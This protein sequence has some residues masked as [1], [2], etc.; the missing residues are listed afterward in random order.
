MTL[1]LHASGEYEYLK[2]LK[3]F[4][5]NLISQLESNKSLPPSQKKAEIDRL[6]VEYD[7]KRKLARFG[8]F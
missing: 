5:R 6:K 7:K 1:K 4:Y 8:L 3:E 2:A